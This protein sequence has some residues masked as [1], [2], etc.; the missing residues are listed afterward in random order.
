MKIISPPQDILKDVNILEMLLDNSSYPSPLTDKKRYEHWDKLFR[1]WNKNTAS[2]KPEQ[3]WKKMKVGRLLK[4]ST[5]P[6]AD[7]R[8]HSFWFCQLEELAEF[9][10][11]IDK[12]AADVLGADTPSAFDQTRRN[13]F[14]M[15]GFTN[16]AIYSSQLEGAATT[17]IVAQK[18]L[19][20]PKPKPRNEG[21]TMI[22]NNHNAM[23][24][25]DTIKQKEL[26]LSMILQ[27]Q[28]ILTAGTLK[29]ED[30]GRL[31]QQDDIIVFDKTD[32]TVMHHPPSAEKLYAR[33][34]RLC[35]F[36]NGKTPAHFLHPALRAIIIHFMLAFDHP[37][38]D[39]NGRTARA[40]FYW[41]MAHNDYW[42]MSFVSISEIIKRA[43][44]KYYRAFL[45]SETD[46][47]D[48][49]YFLLHQIDSIKKAFAQLDDYIKQEER[50]RSPIERMQAGNLNQRQVMLLQQAIQ[51]PL[52]SFSVREHQM[53]NNI[54]YPTARTDLLALAADG[55]FIRKKS[56]KEFL[57][58]PADNLLTLLNIKH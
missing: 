47:N 54:S 30:R 31:R 45:H 18:I 34:E 24:F 2:E 14:L 55:F 7:E 23:K 5:L 50:I 33:M 57:Y 42:L 52:Q 20:A 4:K 37:F 25:I 51:N 11:W 39:G 21:E 41:T 19:S 3:C 46:E 56:G 36:A 43:Q 10:H 48:V 6:F 8:D 22:V 35:D 38:V 40:L 16:E 12:K 28:G 26:T 32:N 9:Q 53:R 58:F 15:E 29:D 44:R 17:R 49:T 1:S 13:K 27:L